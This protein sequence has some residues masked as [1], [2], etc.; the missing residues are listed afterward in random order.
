MVIT[1]SACGI[2]RY[3]NSL[4]KFTVEECLLKQQVGCKNNYCYDM[5]YMHNVKYFTNHSIEQKEESFSDI[6]HLTSS[7]KEIVL[8]IKNLSEHPNENL[9]LGIQ[10]INM[11]DEKENTQRCGLEEQRLGAN[12]FGQLNKFYFGL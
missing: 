2:K 3:V 10:V 12:N 7:E 9:D 11:V 5:Q 8:K 4:Q 6:M 1:Q